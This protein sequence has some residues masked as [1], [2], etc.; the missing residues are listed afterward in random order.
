MSST[1]MA[2]VSAL[3]RRAGDEIVLPR[4]QRLS[5]S[6]VGEKAPGDWVTAVDKEAEAFLTEHLKAL[7]PQAAIVGEEATS[8]APE[9]LEALHNPG[10]VWVIDPLDGTENYI[11]GSPA[12]AVMIGLVCDGRSQGGWIYHPVTQT[13]FSAMLGRGAYRNGT[14]LNPP[15]APQSV[16]GSAVGIST[17]FTP[18][19]LREVVEAHLK[20][21]AETT[22]F[23]C[24][25]LEY[26]ALAMGDK[27]M[28]LFHRLL[29][30][31]HV[32]GLLI[33][34]EVGL[35]ARHFTGEVYAPG[36]TRT[37]LIVAANERLW[38]ESR[39]MLIP[40]ALRHASLFA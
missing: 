14:R 22:P 11:S 10:A 39:D 19:P 31:D 4:W 12:F 28:A 38:H 13:L 9:C 18:S 37:G 29:P 36:A 1:L 32:P 8:L 30:W 17:R 3:I 5:P 26:A 40:P 16:R 7:H 33:A 34:Q 24:A 21:F 6:E 2:D 27:T 35:W 25:G 20:L 23:M 15:L